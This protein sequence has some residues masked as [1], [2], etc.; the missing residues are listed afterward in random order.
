M[1]DKSISKQSPHEDMLFWKFT[2]TNNIFF[3]DGDAWAKH[4]QTVRE[5]L[6]RNIPV[7]IF[8]ALSHKLLSVLSQSDG[9]HRPW[10]SLAHRF[11]LDVVGQ[12]ILGYN[13]EALEQP[14]GFLVK[15]YRDIM[16]DISQPLY[17]AFPILERW[18]PR[19]QLQSRILNLRAEFGH[20]LA[21]KLSNPGQDFMSLMLSR[22]P[23]MTDI[24]YLDN[25]VTMFMAGHVRGFEAYLV[26]DVN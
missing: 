6:H 14:D 1:E 19:T 22:Q 4:A 17:I 26:N 10:S 12:A 23:A 7:D 15:Q 20:L 24:E 25:V 11:T 8:V 3:S 2:G 16:H 21:Q 5:V 18:L 9:G 13:F